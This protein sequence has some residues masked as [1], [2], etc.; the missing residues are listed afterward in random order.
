M[1]ERDRTVLHP[2]FEELV[3]RTFGR[4]LGLDDPRL[5]GYLASLL[6]RFAHRDRLYAV[7]DASGRPLQ[8]VAAMLM[9]GEV[10]LG[11]ASFD[12]ERE[13]HKHVGDFTLFVTGVWPEWHRRIR[14]TGGADALLDY[15]MTGKQSYYIASTFDHGPYRD[16]APVLR[17]LSAEYEVCEFGLSLVRAELDRLG[18]GP[19][20]LV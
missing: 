13:V 7:R 17:R 11:A 16:E 14:R 3:A 20:S 9:E 15:R 1:G 19:E 12:R 8:D 5:V 10:L 4:S 6:A 18:A 2:L